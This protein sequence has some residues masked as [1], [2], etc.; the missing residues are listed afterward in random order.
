MFFFLIFH[1][2]RNHNHG[3]SI[4]IDD[5]T[6]FIQNQNSITTTNTTTTTNITTN[7]PNIVSEK[8]K[9][10][11]NFQKNNDSSDIQLDSGSS[12]DDSETENQLQPDMRSERAA[13]I[14]QQSQHGRQVSR[15]IID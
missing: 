6:H 3:V 11:S 2:F 4:S 7:C 5:T 12:S 1:L 15:I 8:N 13:S 9:S 14:G 10:I